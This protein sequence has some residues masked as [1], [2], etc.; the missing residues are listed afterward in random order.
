MNRRMFLSS[1]AGAGAASLVRRASAQAKPLNL[2]VT[3]L[4]TFVVNAGSLNWV[5]CKVFTN[6]GL[7]GLGEGSV[8][9]KEA[10]VAQAIMEHERYLV[11]KDPTDIELHWQAM[12]RTPRWRG[13]PILN[14]AISAVEIALWDILGQALGVPI[15]KL[16]GGAARARIRMYL[17]VGSTP[18]DFLRAKE[19][20]YTAAKMTPLSPENEVVKPSSMIRDAVRKVAAI[21]KA[22]GDDFDIAVDAHG[23]CTTTMAIDFCT[24]VEEYGLLFVEEPTQLEDLGE[25]AL[26]REK[27]R[28]HLATG[29]RSFTKFGFADFCSRHLVD[30]IQPDVCHAGGILE[31]K[32]IGALAETYRVNLAPHNP[33]S[34]VSTMASLHVDATT[35]SAAIQESTLNRTAWIEELFEG[36]GPLIHNGYAELPTR[37]GL[38]VTLNEKIAA[39]HPY[40]PTNRP[41]YRF[42]DGSVTDQ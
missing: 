17:D 41:E 11:G 23:R 35:P 39:Q 22:V 6:G 37:P 19:Q 3:A 5:L 1:L 9:S 13:G 40:K 7:V 12:F 34:H 21:R 31:L 28:T 25:L 16:L 30:Y 38:G 36:S 24:R 33:Q 4:K 18:D 27:T 20:G 10:T 2:K 26:L 8:T 14:S 42:G 15:Y 29:E 32:K